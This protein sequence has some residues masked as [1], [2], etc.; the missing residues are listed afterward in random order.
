MQPKAHFFIP[1]TARFAAAHVLTPLYIPF[2]SAHSF[3]PAQ[4]RNA[5]FF[6]A[7]P[8]STP[9][10]AAIFSATEGP[11]AIQPEAGASPFTTASA[12]ASHPAKPQ[13]PQFPP[14]ST[15]LTA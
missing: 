1:L 3:V 10:M 9:R 11:P 4:A 8:A 12:K 7:L 13:P 2:E 14:E 15:S 6:S 5:T